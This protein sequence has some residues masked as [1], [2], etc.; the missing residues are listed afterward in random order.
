M[1][2]KLSQKFSHL[3]QALEFLLWL[4][5]NE[6]NYIHEN[7]GLIP[8]VAQWVKDQVLQWV[9]AYIAPIP[10]QVCGCRLAAVAW[11]WPLAWEIPYATGVT[12]KGKK[13]EIKNKKYDFLFKLIFHLVAT[14]V[15]F[16]WVV[17][18]IEVGLSWSQLEQLIRVLSACRSVG[19]WQRM[20]STEMVCVCFPWSL[21]F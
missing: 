10:L 18:V 4:S 13:S 8:G 9:E 1:H 20:S 7:V 5:G 16:S 2:H 3:R 17:L 15:L 14:Q 19:V 21:I 12:L 6:H 11:I